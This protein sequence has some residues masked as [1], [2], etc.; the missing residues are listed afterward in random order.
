MLG[1]DVDKAGLHEPSL[2][3][4]DN[5]DDQLLEDSQQE[6]MYAFTFDWPEPI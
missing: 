3:S 5:F 6:Y 4:F 1:H 2:A